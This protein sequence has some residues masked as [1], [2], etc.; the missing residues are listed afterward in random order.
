MKEAVEHA[1]IH[2]RRAGDSREESESLILLVMAAGAGPTPAPEV[3]D[4]C[5]RLSTQTGNVTLEAGILRIRAWMSAMTGR[6]DDARQACRQAK[7]ILSRAGMTMEAAA[8]SHYSGLVELLANDAEAAE[9]ELRD[10]LH[11]LQ[12]MDER[13]LMSTCEALLAR[14]VLDQGRDDEAY[15]L[16]VASE[17]AAAP[18]DVVTQL[19]WRGVRARALAGRGEWRAAEDLARSAVRL[20]ESTRRAQLSRRRARG[21]GRSAPDR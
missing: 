2:A 13:Y 14:A 9:R 10:G 1:L 7:M 18:E 12:A 6:F 21:P 3:L 4:M 15:A 5:D 19:L 11:T 16:T 17:Q 8:N 20:V